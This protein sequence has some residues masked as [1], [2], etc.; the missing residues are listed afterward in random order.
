VAGRGAVRFTAACKAL[1]RQRFLPIAIALDA[2]PEA[3][4]VDPLKLLQVAREQSGLEAD[5]V[6][7]EIEARGVG[8]DGRVNLGVGDRGIIF[9][10]T[11]PD[12]VPAAQRRWRQVTVGAQ[13]IPMVSPDFDREPLPLRFRGAVVP[14]RCT[15]ERVWKI[16]GHIPRDLTAKIIYG[17]DNTGAASEIWTIEV[18]TMSVRQTTSDRV[19]AAW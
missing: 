16:L 15:F 14:P 5:A 18:P 2:L 10:F 12:S 19:C 6:L 13:G 9:T 17:R 4:N 8:T 3:P 11:D 1:P 7:L